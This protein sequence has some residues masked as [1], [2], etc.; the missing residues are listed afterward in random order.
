MGVPTQQ[1]LDSA[2]EIAANMREA[3]NDPE[4]L[5]KCLLNLSYRMSLMDKV[6]HYAKLYLH[7]GHGSHEHTLLLRAIEKAESAALVTTDKTDYGL[8]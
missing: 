1:E 8:E 7:S 5:A 3:G 6:L 4:H 2:L